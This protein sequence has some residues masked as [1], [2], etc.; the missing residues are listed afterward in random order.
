MREHT[1]T[2]KEVH[3][4]F[5]GLRVDW[6]ELNSVESLKP[7]SDVFT[8][9]SFEA[10]R[11][12]LLDVKSYYTSIHPRLYG[13][14]KYTDK[15][16]IGLLV[17]RLCDD[18]D[19][20]IVSSSRELIDKAIDMLRAEQVQISEVKELQPKE[21][22]ELIEAEKYAL[23]DFYFKLVLRGY[24]YRAGFKPRIAG[25][26][27]LWSKA[28]DDILYS[29]DADLDPDT[30]KGYVSVDIKMPPSTTLWDEVVSRSMSVQG[31]WDYVDA[32]IMVPYGNRYAYGRIRVY[33]QEG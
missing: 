17:K 2:Y 1:Y 7:L 4:S 25:R 26:R 6:L 33:L 24:L 23:L 13:L 20:Y 16:F 22:D 14:H 15:Y 5:R 27:A 9:L 28:N 3:S 30:L 11:I 29:L 21:I 18:I 31:V 10:K 19:L 12:H 32:N 8:H